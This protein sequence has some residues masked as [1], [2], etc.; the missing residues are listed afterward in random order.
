[1]QIYKRYIYINYI[2]F[3]KKIEKLLFSLQQ[4]II[5]NMAVTT[6]EFT[7]IMD[8]LENNTHIS[9]NQ[10]KNN[11]KYIEEKTVKF[12]AILLIIIIILPMAICDIYYA[13]N[14]DTCVHNNIPKLNLTL[15]KYLLVSGI[16]TLCILLLS[17]FLI[18]YNIQFECF[19]IVYN[20]IGYINT[21]FTII[22]TIIGSVI[23]W[24]YLDIDDCSNNVY[25]YM[26]TSLIIK[27]A[28]IYITIQ[29]NN[30]KN[31]NNNI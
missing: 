23:F 2:S 14:D 18:Y 29:Q 22:W 30:N 25:E 3:I 11:S 4:I 26:F 31:N 6:P 8:N 28:S 12:C 17:C 13:I 9:T 21:L 7:N 15:Y 5:S 24:G 20:I 16:Q 27:L 10:N 19:H 1:M